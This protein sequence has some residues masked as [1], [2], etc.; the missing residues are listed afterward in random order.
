V[1]AVSPAPVPVE[2][3]FAASDAADTTRPPPAAVPAAHG[4]PAEAPPEGEAAPVPTGTAIRADPH[5]APVHR[6]RGSGHGPR[7]SLG[8]AIAMCLGAVVIGFAVARLAPWNGTGEPPRPATGARAPE[9]TRASEPVAP[10]VP[11][12]LVGT[13]PPAPA[14]RSSE[15]AAERKRPTLRRAD[16]SGRGKQQRAT[17]LL[18]VTAPQGAEILLD[19]HRIGRGSTRR[20]I[21]VG[22]HRVEVRHGGARVGE[23]FQVAAGETWTYAVTPRQ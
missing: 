23:N 17:G 12:A 20:R 22:N 21:P 1:P 7:V 5:P 8:V 10:A 19:G 18:D 2:N 3:D 4:A 16:A 9:E 13:S 11:S 15:S 6:E 14:R